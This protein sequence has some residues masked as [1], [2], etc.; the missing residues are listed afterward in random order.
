MRKCLVIIPAYNAAKTLSQLISQ[1]K[2][3]HQNFDVLIVDDGSADESGRIAGTAGAIVLTHG[4]NLGKGEALKAGFA[5]AVAH[6]YDAVI[7]LD[8]D[9]QHD[10]AEIQCF[11][12]AYSDDRTI[13][14]GIRRRDK[15][16]PFARKVSNSLTS[17]VASVFCGVRVLD[18]QSGYRLI[19]TAILKSITLSSSR[20]DLEPELLIKAARAG[21]DIKSVE[22]STI[23]HAGRSSINPLIDTIRFLIMLMKSLFW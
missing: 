15:T 4:C 6:D 17:F 19:P 10:P 7:T 8:A 18:S 9:L 1:V 22:I 12:N 23:Y 20:F 14:V 3:L 16:M 13:L 11:L 5:Y 21:Y 2:R